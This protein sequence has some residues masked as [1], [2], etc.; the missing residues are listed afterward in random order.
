ML[1]IGCFW[2]NHAVLPYQ[3]T[4]FELGGVKGPPVAYR[5]RDHAFQSLY[6]DLLAN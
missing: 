4:S 6:T 1:K 5:D 3:M 2:Q